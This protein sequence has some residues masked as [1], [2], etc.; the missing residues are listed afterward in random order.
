MA[1]TTTFD[2]PYA[3]RP[4][5]CASACPASGGFMEY[6]RFSPSQ[7]VRFDLPRGTVSLKGSGSRVLVP[8]ELL[9]EM[10][11]SL[12][13]EQRRDFGSRWGTELGRTVADRLGGEVERASLETVVEHLGGELALAGLG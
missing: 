10:W 11:A 8:S 3:A 7:S 1:Q 4:I 5:L 9:A 6:P 2:T 13:A 12:T